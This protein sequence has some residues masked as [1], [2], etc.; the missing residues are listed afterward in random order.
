MSTASIL[1]YRD[2]IKDYAPDDWNEYFAMLLTSSRAECTPDGEMDPLIDSTTFTD[3]D[4]VRNAHE[5]IDQSGFKG[6]EE[7]DVREFVYPTH[8]KRHVATNTN[9]NINIESH[10]E[11]V[12]IG[13]DAKIQPDVIEI[14]MLES[15]PPL[16]TTTSAE[17]TETRKQITFA[18]EDVGNI[19]NPQKASES[20]RNPDAKQRP[21][22]RKRKYEIS[23]K[24]L[25]RL[26]SGNTFAA[27]I[28]EMVQNAKLSDVFKYRCAYCPK[29]FENHALVYDHFRKD[30]AKPKTVFMFKVAKIFHCYYCRHFNSYDDLKRHC[31]Q[32]HSRQL[33][34]M[35]DKF[36]PT[37]CGLCA[38]S[39]ENIS[40]VDHFEINHSSAGVTNAIGLE[41]Y[42]TDELL[43]KIAAEQLVTPKADQIMFGCP[44]CPT[45]RHSDQMELVK[46]LREHFVEYQCKFCDKRFNR[47]ETLQRHHRVHGKRAE[48]FS[49]ADAAIEN[50]DKYLEMKIYFP[51]GLVLTKRELKKTKFGDMDEVKEWVKEIGA[52]DVS[53]TAQKR[54][55]DAGEDLRSPPALPKLKRFKLGLKKIDNQVPVQPAQQTGERKAVR[56]RRPPKKFQS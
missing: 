9:N 30:H 23:Q 37:K 20:E 15:D 27:M 36:N 18:V 41:N 50:F 13:L 1:S 51:N 35:M 55:P 16:V 8:L 31:D 44:I 54:R 3:E 7:V 17:L 21:T 42:L 2:L 43:N 26:K 11:A 25:N 33:F 24:E 4:S 34:I 45:S 46:H 19:A 28:D 5:S 56:N 22:K 47:I 38:E 53:S 52:S 32:K 48:T 6:F 49:V 12:Q 40:I 10:N 29:S 14:D 39:M